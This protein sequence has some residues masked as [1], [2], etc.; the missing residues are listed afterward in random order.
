MTLAEAYKVSRLYTGF[1]L[2]Q[3]LLRH[4]MFGVRAAAFQRAVSSAATAKKALLS[5]AAYR[6]TSDPDAPPSYPAEVQALLDSY[7]AE[8]AAV[9]RLFYGPSRFSRFVDWATSNAHTVVFDLNNAQAQFVT[10][11]STPASHHDFQP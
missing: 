10:Q 7:D 2:P 8:I 3:T 11:L 5:H 4:F 6:H 9:T 1:M